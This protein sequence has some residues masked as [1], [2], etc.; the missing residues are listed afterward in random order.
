MLFEQALQAPTFLERDQHLGLRAAK[1]WQRMAAAERELVGVV[2][3][4]DVGVDD[5]AV[6]KNAGE[7]RQAGSFGQLVH[8]LAAGDEDRI[9]LPHHPVELDDPRPQ[10]VAAG[11]HSHQQASVTQVLH[12]AVHGRPGQAHALGNG[13]GVDLQSIRAEEVQDAQ[14]LAQ[15]AHFAPKGWSGAWVAVW[16]STIGRPIDDE[17]PAGSVCSA[18]S[19]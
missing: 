6:I 11:I 9:V 13:V 8:Q 3:L 7:H 19:R 10:A 1:E 16:V 2:G 18:L 14:H 4:G 17:K 12:V 5:V 15:A